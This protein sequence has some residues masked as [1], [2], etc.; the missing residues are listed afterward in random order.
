MSLRD[1]SEF[2]RD[3]N[4]DEMSVASHDYI[5]RIKDAFA[6]CVKV[7]DDRSYNYR[8]GRSDIRGGKKQ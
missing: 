4:L 7:V 2:Y 3:V 6:E 1:L 5:R 8:P